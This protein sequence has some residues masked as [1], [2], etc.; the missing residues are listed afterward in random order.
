MRNHLYI[1]S[2]VLLAAVSAYSMSSLAL[3]GKN[4]VPAS[5]SG[6]TGTPKLYGTVIL[7]DTE[8]FDN[9]GVYSIP[10]NDSESFNRFLE[11]AEGFGR[12]SG[13][14]TS[15][16]YTAVRYYTFYGMSY[17][18]AYTY[19]LNT[20]EQ[21][22]QMRSVPFEMMAYDLGYDPVSEQVYGCFYVSG[23]DS[24][25]W[26][27]TADYSKGESHKIAD[28][29]KWNALAFDMRGRAYAID[30]KGNLLNVNKK[31]GE[32]SLI[33]FTG[34][35]PRYPSS[36]TIDPES[37][38]MYWTVCPEDGHSYL[39]KVDLATGAST[40]LMQ[41]P[42]DEQ[43]M[44]LFIPVPEAIGSAPAAASDLEVSFPKGSH[45]G[46]ITFT[47]PSTTYDGKPLSG[48]LE[49]SISCD[50]EEDKTGEGKPG[51]NVSVAYEVESRGEYLFCVT[52]SN[53]V[54]LSPRIRKGLYVGNGVP[55]STEASFKYSDGVATVS[56]T[57]VTESA[58]GGYIDPAEVTYRVKRMPDNVMVEEHTKSTSTV[59]SLPEPE[60]L[61]TYWFEVTPIFATLE[62]EPAVTP[63]I[64][65]GSVTPP[66]DQKFETQ[67]DFNTFIVIDGNDDG[68]TWE[69]GPGYPRLFYSDRQGDDWLITPAI[70]LTK[71]EQYSISF[72][73]RNS[74]G[75]FNPEKIEVKIGEEASAEAMTVTLLPPTIVDNE[76]WKNITMEFIPRKSGRY[77]LGIHGISDPNMFW[78]GVDN[79]SI[80][81]GRSTSAPAL[82]EDMK[83]VADF[84][85]G[86]SVDLSF[87]L[88]LVSIA[89]DQLT[90]IS[91]VELFRDAE[92][93]PIKVYDE[94]NPGDLLSYHDSGLSE[95]VHSY[96]ITSFNE[97][98]AGATGVVSTFVGINV[99]GEVSDIVL[100]EVG[101]GDAS[102]SWNPP[103]ADRDG[104]PI[105]PAFVSYK[106]VDIYG[107]EYE[108]A[109][110]SA[111]FN[112]LM[113]GEQEFVRFGISSVTK[114][115]ES[116]MVY[117]EMVPMGTPYSLP[118]R[119]SFNNNYGGILGATKVNGETS[120]SIGYDGY[121]PGVDSQD[122]DDA[123]IVM[124]A[125]SPGDTGAI[126][127]GKISLKNSEEPSV[128][129]YVYQF[130]D[131]G[132]KDDENEFEIE[133][134]EA[135]KGE[136]KSIY[137]VVNNTLP[138]PGWNRI[139]VPLS[140]F[141][142]QTIQLRFKATANSCASYLID[143]II[144]DHIYQSNIGVI[145]IE[146]PEMVNPDEEFEIKADIENSSL[147]DADNFSAELVRDGEVID[148]YDSLSLPQGQILSIAF[149]RSLSVVE[150]KNVKYMIRLSW[151]KDEYD[152]DNEVYAMSIR[153]RQT[154]LPPVETIRGSV[155][156]S[157]VHLEWDALDMSKYDG[158][159]IT[160]SFE[161]YE[162]FSM[163]PGGDWKFVDLDKAR[164]AVPQGVEIEG[165]GD[166]RAYAFIVMNA[167]HP[168]FNGTFTAHSGK[169]YLMASYAAAQN[170]DWAISPRLSGDAQTISFYAKNYYEVHG[171]ETIEV[172][173]SV[174]GD[175]PADFTATALTKT[176]EGNDWEL[177]SVDLPEG[178]R[179]A[180]IHYI[181]ND[182]YMLFI[183]DFRYVP[184]Q[185]SERVSHIGYNVYRNGERL[186]TT[187]VIAPSYDDSEPSGER[188]VY[189]VTAV[190]AE[191]ESAPSDSFTPDLSGVDELG[192]GIKVLCNHSGVSVYGAAGKEILVYS[193]GGL[194]VA[195]VKASSDIVEIP[196]AQGVYAVRIGT[197][198]VKVVIP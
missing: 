9:W 49:W 54:G 109:E 143:N 46:E 139:V 37:G 3:N 121:F 168:T 107:D 196:L 71:D 48:N 192:N 159:I 163:N 29:E 151:S 111:T 176:L 19:D 161:D 13:V 86:D 158:E 58:D 63:S 133:I 179:Y 45:K 28:V 56:W 178:A 142:D 22:G 131:N 69:Y 177:I 193:I 34:V 117:S 61:V 101:E 130:T 125:G 51:E 80:R 81:S 173:Y 14:A 55:C 188:N 93:D 113:P 99:P 17:T 174:T 52:V 88:P 175:E 124:E 35:V 197:R 1:I 6:G 120:W 53:D 62:G 78:V 152:P 5:E 70:N 59:A 82:P 153:V 145:N 7:A 198:I 24:K 172:R 144:V 155:K 156:E 140:E 134:R 2:G 164:T 103:A 182:Q 83:A 65:L 128:S 162:A 126:Y 94:V 108:M 44:G 146:V 12:G 105:N 180:A 185:W 64:T 148:C 106:L 15:S 36:G 31:T 181:S 190:Y 136:Y 18:Q 97:S 169:Q 187:P 38:N 100:K 43:V 72:D 123:M 27:G 127:T 77:Y 118:Y 26:F 84:D 42:H 141:K 11:A 195:S 183:D 30:M 116:P 10:T 191:G 102:I 114:A 165:L 20:W 87:K 96:S 154:D 115:G 68:K 79:L 16:T 8:E 104:Y 119:D 132:V 32:T 25:A 74:Y 21:I 4:D 129:V 166:D 47:L 137:R 75:S 98:G 50:G 160:D 184:A 95:G 92:T 41:F 112:A 60:T 89:G 194:C 91:R 186:N 171:K 90:S 189:H 138:L 76:P 170:D 147:T 167:D 110:T 122:G 57:A 40:K 135:S 85:G 150:T 66:Y 23:S 39:Y 157:G 33:G 67:E 73:V 149:K